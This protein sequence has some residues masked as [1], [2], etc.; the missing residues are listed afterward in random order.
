MTV[1]AQL[2]AAR[3]WWQSQGEG[4]PAWEDIELV[5]TLGVRDTTMIDQLILAEPA[6]F[7]RHWN[8][9]SRF[10]ETAPNP[11][12][13]PEPSSEERIKR[14]EQWRAS[15]VASGRSR[16]L[17]RLGTED[18]V[19]LAN[20]SLT[21][22]DEIRSALFVDAKTAVRKHAEEISAALQGQG[23]TGPAA[24]KKPRHRRT[25][26]AAEPSTSVAAASEPHLQTPGTPSVPRADNGS[27]GSHGPSESSPRGE[28]S[29]SGFV[30]FEF[31][32]DSA[33]DGYETLRF[34][35]GDDLNLRISWSPATGAPVAI[36]RV[37]AN[38]EFM[39]VAS[40]DFGRQVV[41]TFDNEVFEPFDLPD[42]VEPVR[43]VVV[44]VY[45]GATEQ[46]ARRTQPRVHA[47]G[48]CVL[49]VRRFQIRED[50]GTVAGHWEAAPGISRVDVLRVPAAEA[51]HHDYYDSSRRLS[52][53]VQSGGFTDRS[54]EPGQE[55][56]YRV[57][58][59][60]PDAKGASDQ[61]SP[62]VSARVHITA[63]VLGVGDL[64]VTD[65]SGQQ[66]SVDL[67]WTMPPVGSVEIYRTQR[68]L[69][70]GL[71]SR[72]LDR[73][74][75]ERGGLRDE[76]KLVHSREV[77]DGIAQMRHVPWPND[78]AKAYFTPVTVASET[79]IKV[80]SPKILTRQ[81]P[82]E[83]V[84]LIERVDE[85]LLTFTWP[86]GTTSA[87]IYRGGAGSPF[88]SA[89]AERATYFEVTADN[90][91]K[92]GGVHLPE[93]LPSDG[94]S[95][96][97]V[98]ASYSSGRPVLAPPVTVEYSGLTRIK[99]HLDR[100]Q[101]IPQGFRLRRRPTS[102]PTSQLRVACDQDDEAMTLVLVHNPARLPLHIRDG[103]EL[104][105]VR[106]TI[107]PAP[108][109]V[110]APL[111]LAGLGGYVRLFVDAPRDVT[112]KVAVLDPPINQLRLF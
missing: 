25:S 48:R 88:T 62:A 29:L 111:T 49:P 31:G 17:G 107:G 84:R 6:S 86:E 89:M 105:R 82:F 112:C 28:T 2:D 53:G 52:E 51:A 42:L 22:P 66:S 8:A 83:N 102:T 76:Q 80:G 35:S 37:V 95:V 11:E 94:C 3:A 96:H 67:Q 15:A 108:S 78:W 55:Y 39:P 90:Y 46:E 16:E 10:V 72:V 77:V 34:T 50:Q 54:A 68:P 23:H 47:T 5:V 13:D 74:A 7:E 87:K 61:M 57:Y 92:F 98:A 70:A 21:T 85:Q 97:V 101:Q 24:P 14:L 45:Q 75:L 81:R 33:A 27:A 19:R 65:S 106:A 104:D 71:D 73:A 99:Y 36:Y 79:Q 100:N 32:K 60:A 56:E 44:W 91:T 64:S 1:Q 26:A 4:R 38:H 40:P 69:S 18:L 59:V 109:P 103:L 58:A 20:S 41:A 30:D 93:R 43:Q 9:V 12:L 63:P 110:G